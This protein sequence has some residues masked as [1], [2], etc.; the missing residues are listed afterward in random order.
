MASVCAATLAPA[1]AAVSALLAGR[2]FPSEQPF[3]KVV[4][5]CRDLIDELAELPRK[6]VDNKL[7]CEV[8]CCC[9]ENPSVS[10]G[11]REMRQ[12]CVHETLTAAD[13]ALGWQSRYKSEIS[14]DMTATDDAGR[15]QPRP[16]MH[17][18]G[19]GRDT[20][21]PST[22]WQGRACEEIEGYRGG[23]GQVRR[24]D[25]VI[26]KDPSLPPTRDNIV[27]V[28]E[29]KFKGD[30]LSRGQRSAYRQIAG[31]RRKLDVMTEGP[32]PDATRTCNCPE[33]K[34]RPQPDP[35]LVPVP[36]PVPETEREIDWG[37]VGK[38]A[39]WGTLTALAAV[40]TVAAILSLFDG[41]AGDVAGA[42]ATGGAA[43]RTAAAFARI[44]RTATPAL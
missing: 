40:G 21:R 1:V 17:R 22:W 36:Q 39:L 16:L 41:P 33:R 18:D 34:R 19:Q 15:K 14:Y 42:V 27:R 3:R 6:E 25:V 44:F 20:T 24:P 43:A 11:G 8:M 7:L 35:V 23:R 10:G 31:G 30:R 37:E 32:M 2:G 4:E 12:Q 29:M 28:V 26:V 38:T 9:A 13:A 5:T